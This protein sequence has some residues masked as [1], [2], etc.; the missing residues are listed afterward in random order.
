MCH[1]YPTTSFS[2]SYVLPEVRCV[3]LTCCVTHA[4][5]RSEEEKRQSRSHGELEGAD[6]SGEGMFVGGR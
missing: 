2:I 3:C 6:V 4:D 1:I 5:D